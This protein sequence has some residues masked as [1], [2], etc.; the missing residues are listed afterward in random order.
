MYENRQAYSYKL[1]TKYTISFVNVS[2]VQINENRTFNTICTSEIDWMKR[3]LQSI[4][5]YFVCVFITFSSFLIFTLLH[6]ILIIH[7]LKFIHIALILYYSHAICFYVFFITHFFFCGDFFFYKVYNL[8]NFYYFFSRSL[9]N[10]F[11]F[12]FHYCNFCFVI[13]ILDSFEGGE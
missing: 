3:L 12:F 4:D 8:P 2:L 10:K 1:R 9:I 7:P 5:K 6:H 13:F 11:F